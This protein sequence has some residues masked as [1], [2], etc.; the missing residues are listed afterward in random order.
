MKQIEFSTAGSPEE[1][2]QH[3]MREMPA[4]GGRVL[5]Q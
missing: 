1:V 3:G 5:P 4:P 2:V